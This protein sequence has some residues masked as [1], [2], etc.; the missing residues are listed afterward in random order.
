[1][2]LFR[3][4]CLG[5]R[6]L[7]QLSQMVMVLKEEL[8]HPTLHMLTIAIVTLLECYELAHLIPARLRY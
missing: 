2:H 5:C 4:S 7:N 6:K 1:M 8:A 3:G